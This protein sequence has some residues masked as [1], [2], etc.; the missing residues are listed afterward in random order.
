M[1]IAELKKLVRPP[2]K[3]FEVRMLA[4]WHKV[5]DQLGTELPRDYRDF[6]FGYGG[7]LFAGLYRA[8]NPF[9]ASDDAPASSFRPPVVLV[10][11]PRISP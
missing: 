7:G 10:L 3:P 1:S 11:W 9:A 6:I 2:V 4:Q 5:E 8:C